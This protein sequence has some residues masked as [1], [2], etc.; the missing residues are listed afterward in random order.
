[1]RAYLQWYYM[2]DLSLACRARPLSF[3]LRSLAEIT[4]TT[5]MGEGRL[6]TPP[7][8]RHNIILRRGILRRV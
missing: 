2:P 4:E 6:L 1:M 8:P 7:T 3:K 5:R